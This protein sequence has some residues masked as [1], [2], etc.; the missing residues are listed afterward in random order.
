MPSTLAQIRGTLSAA[1]YAWAASL[2]YG[3]QTVDFPKG[4]IALALTDPFTNQS[5]LYPSPLIT[6][7]QLQAIDARFIVLRDRWRDKPLPHNFFWV[8][9]VRSSYAFAAGSINY[10]DLGATLG[11]RYEIINR[12]YA[13]IG[14][15]F[16]PFIFSSTKLGTIPVA[17][18]P[19][20]V[21]SAGTDSTIITGITSA[22]INMY[23]AGVSPRLRVGTYFYETSALR[24]LM[25][26]LDF[27]VG[28]NL[29]IPYYREVSFEPNEIKD[30]QDK[31]SYR[32][33]H[34]FLSFGAAPFQKS[35]FSL[36]GLQWSVG[37]TTHF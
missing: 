16:Q 19:F 10:F 21:N 17:P 35:A 29:Y 27:E 37:I 33:S 6:P 23:A 34:D 32:L 1:D 36:N 26:S 8:A 11:V 2:S 15:L 20:F 24:S 22:K 31:I 9:D 7:T 18:T 4:I 30:V 12:F 5:S 3:Q 28:Y 14:V 13:Q 25:F